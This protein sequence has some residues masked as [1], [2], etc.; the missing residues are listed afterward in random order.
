MFAAKGDRTR[1]L[2]FKNLR[3]ELAHKVESALPQ[4]RPAERKR[5]EI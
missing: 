5:F 2:L 1:K 4:T 3:D